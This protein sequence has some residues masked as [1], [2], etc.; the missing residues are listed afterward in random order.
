VAAIANLK[1][2]V[3]DAIAVSAKKALARCHEAAA[4]E[5][6]LADEANERR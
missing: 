3:S 6:A 5:K 1:A 4:R 2:I